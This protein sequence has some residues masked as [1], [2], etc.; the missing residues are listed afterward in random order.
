MFLNQCH[1]TKI[2]YLNMVQ[3]SEMFGEVLQVLIE[4]GSRRI[5]GRALGEREP[6]VLHR[7]ARSVC[8][9]T[10]CSLILMLTALREFMSF[11]GCL[12]ENFMDKLFEELLSFYVKPCN[13]NAHH[14]TIT[15][16]VGAQDHRGPRTSPRWYHRFS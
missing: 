14:C 16:S 9:E 11:I 10:Y 1:H 8:P 2:T 3:K 7:L 6:G 12:R 13:H 5:R 4:A 15:S